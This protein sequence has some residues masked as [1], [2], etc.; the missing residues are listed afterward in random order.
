MT[1]SESDREERVRQVCGA[2]RERER[3]LMCLGVSCMER[4]LHTGRGRSVR[5]HRETCKQREREREKV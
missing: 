3:D 5:R 2:A 4:E 1:D